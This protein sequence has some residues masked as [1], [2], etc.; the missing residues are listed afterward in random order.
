[1][2]G[3][4]NIANWSKGGFLLFIS[5]GFAGLPIKV[6]TGWKSIKFWVE[7]FYFQKK[8]GRRRGPYLALKRVVFGQNWTFSAY[9]EIFA[10]FRGSKKFESENF[11]YSVFHADYRKNIKSSK[12]FIF[13]CEIYF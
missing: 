9:S 3:F 2:V 12:K 4:W 5:S 13:S 7:N 6:Y 8:L 11:S 1:M 10:I